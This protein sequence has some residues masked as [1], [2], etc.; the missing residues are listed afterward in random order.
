MP[1]CCQGAT[2]ACKVSAVDGGH[3]TISGSGQANDP[4]LITADIAV[5]VIDNLIFDMTING[6]GTIADPWL[7]SVNFA[8]TA[9]L[10]DFPDVVD[11]AATTGQVLAW[12]GT[13]WAP[14][15]PTTAAAGSVS[16]DPSL[17]GDGSAGAPLAVVPDSARGL[18]IA[19]TGVGLS[20]TGMRATTRHFPDAT[21]RNAMA[22]GPAV[23]TLTMLDTALGEVDFWDGT[24]WM[25]IADR[26]NTVPGGTE[27][28]QLS[29]PYNGVTPI[30]RILTTVTAT[31]DGTGQFIIL[32][33][34]ALAGKAGVFSVMF[35]E[36]GA[37][38]WSAVLATS[39]GQV[40]AKAYQL[41]D[42]APMVG[43]P[44]TGLV[45]AYVY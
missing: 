14:S 26:V 25:P 33:T 1:T 16:H 29:G 5:G 42:G 21:T 17:T 44:I 10:A 3:M 15:A 32:S 6:T 20:D 11:G 9:R 30:S 8:P 22:P 39:A 38:A 7:L 43:T 36:T 19:A 27:F 37:T 35:Q 40:V 2:C 4:F 18:Q 41:T 12:N 24:K 45:V 31:T 34:A 23:N 13:Q 28:L